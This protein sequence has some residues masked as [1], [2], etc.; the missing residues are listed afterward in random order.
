MSAHRERCPNREQ[1]DEQRGPQAS[2]PV[3]GFALVTH[4]EMASVDF[5]A[6]P[7]KPCFIT[8]RRRRNLRDRGTPGGVRVRQ[9]M[10]TAKQ[11]PCIS[12][13]PGRDR[14]C[15]LGI[16]SP[17]KQAATHRRTLK[18]PA[19]QAS[20]RRNEQRRMTP[21]GDESVRA[22]VRAP[23]VVDPLLTMEVPERNW[24]ARSGIGGHV[25]PANQSFKS[26]V[27]LR[28]RRRPSL[29]WHVRASR[30]G[31]LHAL[32]STSAASKVA[33]ECSFCACTHGT[34]AGT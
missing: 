13:G 30:L 4:L 22:S 25:V 23:E 6:G 12:H 14:T 3:L 16:K 1:G 2:R 33:V 21:F 7:T 31:L 26:C 20:R 28:I 11:N 24:G 5:E 19:N 27:W 9:S 18:V 15:D 8:G 32:T 17:A 10:R 34:S 29:C